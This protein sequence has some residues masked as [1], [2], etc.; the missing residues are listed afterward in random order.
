MTFSHLNRRTHLYLG[1]ALLPWFFLYAVSSIPFSHSPF[2]DSLDEAKGLPNWTK[3]YE[4]PYDVPVPEGDLRPFGA[5][6]LAD[7]GLEGAFGAYRQGP[8]QVNVYVYTF[9][10]STQ[11]KYFLD[12]HRIVVEDKRFRWDHFLTGMHAKGGFEQEGLLHT[13]WAFTVDL[14]A[15]AILLWIAS[16][17]YLWWHIPAVRRSGALTLVA[18]AAAFALFLYK[19]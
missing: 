1:L 16:G 14:V 9:W 8:S 17:L 7:T 6:V 19:L 11:V 12:Q 2:F 3:L 4:R 13:A 15:L 5:R 10:R 18:G